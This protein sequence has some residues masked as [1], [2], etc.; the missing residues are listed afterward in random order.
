M[1]ARIVEARTAIAEADFVSSNQ[2]K[3]RSEKH[4]LVFT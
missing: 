3:Q 4:Q 1:I 2:G